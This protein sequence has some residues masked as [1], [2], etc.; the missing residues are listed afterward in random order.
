MTALVAQPQ[1]VSIDAESFYF[2]TYKSGVLT[3]GTKCGTTLDHAVTAV[4]YGVDAT[5]GQYYLVRNSW[6]SSWGLGGY[7]KIG[8]APAPGICGINSDVEYPTI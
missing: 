1:S 7:V 3:N 8:M 2:Q 4:G 6:G 5:A